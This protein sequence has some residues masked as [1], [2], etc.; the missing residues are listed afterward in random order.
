[1][2]VFRISKA[3]TTLYGPDSCL[4]TQ[5]IPED[6]GRRLMRELDAQRSDY[7]QMYYRGKPLK[8][9]KAYYCNRLDGAVKLYTYTASVLESFEDHEFNGPTLELRD[10]VR[11]TIYENVNSLVSNLYLDGDKKISY[12]FDK[13]ED[14]EHGSAIANVSL[15]G[16]RVMRLC[17]RPAFDD[18][19]A[20]VKA[21]AARVKDGLEPGPVPKLKEE[22]L[23]DI[24]LPHC[25]LFVLGPETN[26]TYVHSILE[27]KEPVDP[28]YGLTYRTVA[29]HW[30]PDELISV[31][32]PPPGQQEWMVTYHPLQ[33]HADGRTHG[34]N[35]PYHAKILQPGYVPVNPTRLQPEDIAA[36]R[37]R[38]VVSTNKRRR[39]EDEERQVEDDKQ[40]EDS[41]EEEQ[42]DDE[43]EEG[44]TSNNKKQRCAEV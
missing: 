18:W 19:N 14:L 13:P 25:S 29:S 27:S 5:W 32:Q 43:E 42:E 9:L 24:P 3:H 23:I 22:F 37:D 38:G 8:R 15:G 7:K 30:L 40:D 39:N 44:S 1:M 36:V 41:T 4:I 12:H 35:G 21:R 11:G 20:E 10:A 34:Q 17:E 28:R 26:A 31:R 33:P 2:L 16:T 6:D